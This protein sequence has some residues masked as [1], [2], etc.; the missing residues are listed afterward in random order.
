MKDKIA[1]KLDGLREYVRILRDYQEKSIEE[2]EDDITLR[3]AVERY[4]QTA[5]ECTLDIAGMII[6]EE[7]LRKPDTYKDTI[8]IIG[9]KGIIPKDFSKD[10]SLAA[11]FRN[12]LIHRYA[13]IDLKKVYT[14]LK[15]RLSDFDSFAKFIADYLSV[16]M[17]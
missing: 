5:I 7:N 6:S 3:G 2:I 9:E 8:L 4:L 16:R 13:H 12:I 1:D 11:G 17:D 14:F 10:F 15:T